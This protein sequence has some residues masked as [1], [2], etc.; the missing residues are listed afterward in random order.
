MKYKISINKLDELISI[1]E[2]IFEEA[3]GFIKPN[4]KIV[5]VTCSLLQEEN[6]NQI[7]SFCK[8]FGVK[9]EDN[10]VFQTLPKSKGMDGFFSTTLS[11]K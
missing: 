1:Q 9:I 3:L 11:L 10:K 2:K 7:I 8:K 5:Y 6:Q 4:G